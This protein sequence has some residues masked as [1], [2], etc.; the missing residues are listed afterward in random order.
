MPPS[1]HPL[2]ALLPPTVPLA[3]KW[4]Q[5]AVSLPS[6][7]AQRLSQPGMGRRD[8]TTRQGI[9]GRIPPPKEDGDGELLYQVWHSECGLGPLHEALSRTGYSWTCR[10]CG[11]RFDPAELGPHCPT[12]HTNVSGRSD[13]GSAGRVAPSTARRSAGRTQCAEYGA[14]RPDSTGKGEWAAWGHDSC[15]WGCRVSRIH[16]LRS[17]FLNR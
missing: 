16:K 5:T 6:I 8:V 13:G 10:D 4:R 1:Y 2:G 17:E 14:Y 9:A 7:S 15:S 3:A 12:C 11:H